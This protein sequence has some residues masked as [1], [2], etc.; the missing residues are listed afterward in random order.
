MVR[1]NIIPRRL[2]GARGVRLFDIQGLV[3]PDE[4]L[5]EKPQEEVLSAPPVWGISTTE[6]AG[7]LGCCTSSVRSRLSRLGVRKNKVKRAGKPPILYWHRKQVEDIAASRPSEVSCI[8]E[9]FLDAHTVSQ[10]LEIS[11]STLFRY[12]RDGILKAYTVRYRSHVGI[13]LKHFFLRDDVRRL[14][15]HLNALHRKRY[16]KT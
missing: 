8:S 12:V 14:R 15:Y 16:A 10:M 6:A 4:V 3:Y 7:I 1:R 9:R 11:R 13:R 2:I 5:H